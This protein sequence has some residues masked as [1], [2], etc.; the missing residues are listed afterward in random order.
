VGLRVLVD[1]IA[2][3]RAG[4]RARDREAEPGAADALAGRPGETLEELGTNCGGTPSP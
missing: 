4:V 1:E 3:V 2:V